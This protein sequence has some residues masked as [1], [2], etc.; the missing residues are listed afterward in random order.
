MIGYRIANLDDLLDAIGEDETTKILADYSCPLNKDI[1][2]F[3]KHSAVQFSKMGITKTHLV[4]ASYKSCPVLIGYFAIA[5]KTFFI[6]RTKALSSKLRSRIL[7]F[8][9]VDDEANG[10]EISAPLIAQL[11]KN[12]TNDYNSLITGDE[13]LKMA[14]DKVKQIQSIMGG[15]IAYLECA[16]K[17]SLLEFYGRNGFREF[18]RRQIVGEERE[19]FKSEYLVQMLRYFD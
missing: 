8:A 15:K 19:A 4:F 17:P 2:K 3:L 13:L 11:G 6:R 18:D 16:D 5:Y 1:E 10:Y 9:R 12:Y 7:K 14:C